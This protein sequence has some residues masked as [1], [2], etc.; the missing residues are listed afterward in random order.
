MLPLALG[1]L[2]AGVVLKSLGRQQANAAEAEVEMGNASFYREQANF[3]EAA[4]KRSQMIFDRESVVL[5][6]EQHSGLAHSGVDAGT[7]SN[8]TANEQLYRQQEYAAIGKE[9]DFNAHLARLRADQSVAHANALTDS[10][11]EALNIFGD[12]LGGISGIL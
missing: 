2:G 1:V 10:G 11:T 4:G 5:N 6:A 9:A 8:F 3:T 7:L 12:V